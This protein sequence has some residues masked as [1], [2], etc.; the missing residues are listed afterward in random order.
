MKISLTK[1]P[2]IM[3]EFVE[4]R[5][6]PVSPPSM[7][8]VLGG[9]LPWA[10]TKVDSFI[11]QHMPT[12]KRLGLVDES[13]RID[14]DVAKKFINDGFDKSGNIPFFG[15]ILTRQDGEALLDIM[16]KYHD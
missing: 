11:A 6:I 10:L 13:G 1:T 15:F 9:A 14:M 8:F 5:L 4:E 3:T 2:N 16:E 7:K 12:L